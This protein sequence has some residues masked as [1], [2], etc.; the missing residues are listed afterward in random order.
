MPP[1][2]KVLRSVSLAPA[3]TAALSWEPQ[4]RLSLAQARARSRFLK[5]F[6]VVCVLIAGA[7]AGVLIAFM[8]GHA[9]GGGFQVRAKIEA[10]EALTM[11][12]PRFNGRDSDGTMFTITAD[13]AVRV[14][15]A[16][17]DVQLT[18]PRFERAD[19]QQVIAENGVYNAATRALNLT[20]SV[21][22]IGADGS[23]FE[24]SAAE[25]DARGDVIR[26]EMP[27]AGEGVLGEVTADFYELRRSGDHIVLKGRVKGVIRER[28]P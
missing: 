21:T 20:G 11:L 16:S 17:Q 5:V 1:D 7:A 14:G 2:L 4:R 15:D 24:T 25:V 10:Q 3:A 6:R 28:A 18:K 19:G 22:L 23:R 13:R 26:G 9:M 27:I 8:T 12:N